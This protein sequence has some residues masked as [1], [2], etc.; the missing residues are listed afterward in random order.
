MSAMNRAVLILPGLALAVLL[1]C[2]YE[3]RRIDQRL[4]DISVNTSLILD[5]SYPHYP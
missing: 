1:F 4:F 2:A 3:L 5:R